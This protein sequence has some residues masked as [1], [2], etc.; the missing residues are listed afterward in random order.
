MNSSTNSISTIFH[1][2]AR[3]LGYMLSTGG[4]CLELV[5]AA[6]L[7]SAHPW[8]APQAVKQ[9]ALSAGISR[10]VL[11]LIAQYQQG[12]LESICLRSWELRLKSLPDSL[13]VD[14]LGLARQHAYHSILS[15]TK[16]R[17]RSY[18]I[19]KHTENIRADVI[20]Q[21]EM[22]LASLEQSLLA[23]DPRMPG[24]LRAIHA[25]LISYP[26]T[27]HLL[28]DAEI[29]LVINGAKKHTATEIVKETTAKATGTRAKKPSVDEL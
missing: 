6:G 7:S 1:F 20:S 13:H 29:A 17:K 5:Q 27:V 10:M 8:Y 23:A 16:T 4:H 28:E 12:P 18:D 19:M 11:A 22:S 26:E 14:C 24:H 3:G 21:L 25:V 15:P 9:P 2:N